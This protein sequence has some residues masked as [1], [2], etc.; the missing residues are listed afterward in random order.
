MKIG[1]ISDIHGNL[2]ALQAVAEELEREKVDEIWCLGDV[3]GY[4]A[5]PN[6][7]LQWVK[8]NCKYLILGNHELALLNLIDLSMLND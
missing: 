4:G 8:E 5:F 3:V 2:H 6:E 7:C 1:I